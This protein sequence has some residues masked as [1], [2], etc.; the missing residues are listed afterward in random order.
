MAFP[1]PIV[2]VDYERQI[3]RI[4]IDAFVALEEG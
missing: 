1:G 4:D 3:A 2:F